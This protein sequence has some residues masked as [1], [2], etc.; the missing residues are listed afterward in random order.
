MVSIG[1]VCVMLMAPLALTQDTKTP[2]P[3][4]A[5]FAQPVD[6][7]AEAMRKE[8]EAEK[9]KR[10]QAF[11]RLKALKAGPREELQIVAGGILVRRF[12]DGQD[13]DDE[14]DEKAPARP[15]FVI[16]E[17][18][19]DRWIFGSTGDAKSGRAYLEALLQSKIN[20]VNKVRGL[21]P[22]QK[23]KL[24]LAGRGDIKRLF[25]R[26]EEE[27]KEFALVRTDAAHCERFFR[28]L[29]PLRVTMRQ[30]PFEFGSI[31]AKTLQ[32]MLDEGQLARRR[33]G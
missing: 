13:D 19:F 8:A 14:P 1:I 31:F 3:S 30:G 25:D 29:N 28:E 21:T 5:R 17:E 2:R 11:A 23:K 18:S 27:R 10:E 4:F 32:K 20:D 24:L 26:I 15:R 12:L 6:I 22:A 7:A 9:A 33:P 16:A